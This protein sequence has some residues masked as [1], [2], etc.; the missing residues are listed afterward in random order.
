MKSGSNIERRGRSGTFYFRRAVPDDL[1]ARGAPRDL[2]ISLR[3]NLRAEA[4]AAARRLNVLADRLFDQLRQGTMDM[5]VSMKFTPELLSTFKREMF[6]HQVGA[7][8]Q[9][10]DSEGPISPEEA[11]VCAQLADLSAQCFKLDL[12]V[13]DNTVIN[14]FLPLEIERQNLGVAPGTPDWNTLARHGKQVMEQVCLADPSHRA[15]HQRPDRA[16]FR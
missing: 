10:R 8:E 4:I 11:K 2:R 16:G 1:Q 7:L 6:D 3:T 15:P 9:A 13:N 12:A 14:C 5:K